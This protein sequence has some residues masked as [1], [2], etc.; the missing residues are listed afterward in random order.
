MRL[1]AG[2]TQS[3]RSTEPGGL[4]GAPMK[5]LFRPIKQLDRR[6]KLV[7]GILLV[8]VFLTWLAVCLVLV[9]PGAA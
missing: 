1:P 6:K 8:L 4:K 5:D 2:P 7:L 9:L 3:K